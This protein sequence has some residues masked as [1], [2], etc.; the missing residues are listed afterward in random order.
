M[1]WTGFGLTEVLGR[2]G[3]V[4]GR[5]V[6]MPMTRGGSGSTVA[7]SAMHSSA[8][9]A[10]AEPVG[11]EKKRDPPRGWSSSPL[12]SKEGSCGVG[13]LCCA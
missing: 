12:P 3:A 5:A 10:H 1:A 7:A 13:M 6:L 11:I 8:F 4:P 2:Y 9:P